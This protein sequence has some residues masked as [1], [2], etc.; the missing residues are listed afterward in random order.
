MLR[1]S[2]MERIV[3]D[4]ADSVTAEQGRR[5]D[6]LQ[7]RIKR[8]NLETRDL[9]K[10]MQEQL[11]MLANNV[12]ESNMKMSAIA[13]KTGVIT[14]HW[15][16]QARRDSLKEAMAENR[17]T[18]LFEQAQ[19]SFD[20]GKYE[21]ALEEFQF[22]MD[23]YPESKEISTALY[24]LAQIHYAREDYD[25]AASLCKRIFKKHQE[26]E[27]APAALSM[28]IQI[29]EKQGN[30]KNADF[31]RKRLQEIYPESDGAENSDSS[32]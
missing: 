15:K 9:L 25:E 32:E 28:L 11:K 27:D 24:R 22:Y 14:R 29:Y 19:A 18:A 21:N 5:V 1:T 12:N 17:R 7:R 3:Q 10:Q 26:S 20:A 31:V 23:S 13:K 6:S 8:N 4:Q 16:E 2:E 30:T